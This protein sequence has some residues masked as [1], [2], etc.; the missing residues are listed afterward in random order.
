[1]RSGRAPDAFLRLKSL[2]RERR[3]E[4]LY[5]IEDNTSGDLIPFK[6][7][8][9]QKELHAARERCQV[10]GRPA[11]F[12]I[13]KSRQWGVSTFFLADQADAVVFGENVRGMIV[14]HDSDTGSELLRTCKL[15][16]D[17]EHWEQEIGWA[18]PVTRSS[19]GRFE[20]GAPINGFIETMSAKALAAARSR[21]LRFCHCTEIAFWPDAET[22]FLALSQTMPDD[23]NTVFSLESTANGMNWWHDFWWDAHKGENEFEAFFFPWFKHPDNVRSLNSDRY[24]QEREWAGSESRF[25]ATMTEEEK[26]L[27][28]LGATLENLNWRRTTINT[29]C[30]GKWEDPTTWDKFKQEHPATPEEAF[31][32][33]GNRVFDHKDVYAILENALEAPVWVGD[34][35]TRGTSVEDYEFELVGRKHG[36]LR[37]WKRPVGDRQYIVSLDPSSGHPNGDPACMV[38]MDIETREQVAEWHGRANPNILGRILA[39]ICTHYNKAW[40]FPEVNGMATCV[41]AMREIGYENILRRPPKFDRAA[42]DPTADLGW[43]SDTTSKPILIQEASLAL[44]ERSVQF[45]SFDLGEELVCFAQEPRNGRWIYGA[46][47][48]QHD[49]RVIAWAIALI[50]RRYVYEQRLQAPPP[51]RYMNWEE[52][53]MQRIAGMAYDYDPL[54]D[55][56]PQPPDP[57]LDIQAGGW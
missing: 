44:E 55:T 9:A 12:A 36:Q 11:R 49:D 7:N 48:G 46:P 17:E 47:K 6:A 10:E 35:I 15:M 56:V 16:F 30:S 38:V 40:A 57:F 24:R 29:K 39:G 5:Q 53:A 54:V 4:K 21:H 34:V 33:S 41:E 32:T 14:S 31:Q 13:L 25:R 50:G 18:P 28:D 23:K 51:D 26:R 8:Y 43:N 27:E 20:F 37:I 22:Q 3:F 1:M 52:R 45:H 42:Q 2:G 19:K